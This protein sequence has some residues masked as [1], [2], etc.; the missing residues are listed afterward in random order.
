[1]PRIVAIM[2][3]PTYIHSCLVIKDVDNNIESFE[4]IS[5]I[6][7]FDIVRLTF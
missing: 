3:P 6:H 1:M 5:I 2:A 7:M 4:N